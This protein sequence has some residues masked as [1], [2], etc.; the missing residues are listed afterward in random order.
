MTTGFIAREES[1]MRLLTYCIATAGVVMVSVGAWATSVGVVGLF[2]DKAILSVDGG[3]P[4][5][6]SVGQTAGGA[7]LISATSESAVIDVD[8]KRRTLAM[9]QSFASSGNPN[10]KPTVILS[11]DPSGHYFTEGAINGV[12]VAF[13]LDT[14]ATSVAIGAQDAKRMNI[15]YEKSAPIPVS[16]AAGVQK[17]WKVT[18]NTVKVGSITLNQVEGF[19][20]EANINPAL[21][22]MSFLNRTDMKREGQTMTLIQRY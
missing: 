18:F 21:L 2:K 11:A 7:K 13:L 20:V 19:V 17:A 1:E 16:T 12:P 15:N 22:G 14:G 9:G 5:I 6:L 3:P 4:K 10:Q 8:G